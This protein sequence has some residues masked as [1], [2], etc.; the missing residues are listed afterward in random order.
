MNKKFKPL[1]ALPPTEGFDYLQR[2]M[3]KKSE[4]EMSKHIPIIVIPEEA[5]DLRDEVQSLA[6]D[7]GVEIA[8]IGMGDS[9]K[10]KI[11]N[12]LAFNHT[13]SCSTENNHEEKQRGVSFSFNDLVKDA[14]PTIPFTGRLVSSKEKFIENKKPKKERVKN[15]RK[16][17]KRKKA[18]NG[19]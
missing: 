7:N 16:T 10:S 1:I 12:L 15:N 14:E 11:P 4:E 18:K 8:I 13:P 9:G 5:K 2:M 3:F 19:R 6:N 17:K